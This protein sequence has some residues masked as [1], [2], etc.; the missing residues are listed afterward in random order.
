MKKYILIAL[1]PFLFLGCAQQSSVLNL[2]P[3]NS[4][5]N[6]L[7]FAKQVQIN[8]VID[9]R[10]NKSIVATITNS[11]GDVSE[12]VTLQND[13]S[14]WLKDALEKEISRLGGQVVSFSSDIIVDVEIVW[15]KANLSGYSTDNLKGEAKVML[16]IRRGDQTITKNVAQT[17]T[18]FAPIQ[19]SGAFDKFI[20]EL[21]SDIVKR[22]AVQILKS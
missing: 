6:S 17:Q 16:T 1:L 15:L 22:A 10:Q 18:K 4:T 13:I 2:S 8:S 7:G 14:V 9:N 12:Y 11:K 21:L 20:D 3:Y 5:S 19:T